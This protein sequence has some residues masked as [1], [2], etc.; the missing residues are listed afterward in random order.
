MFHDV[1]HI[2]DKPV[3]ILLRDLKRGA[4]LPCFPNFLVQSFGVFLQF[5]A[6]GVARG[7]RESLNRLGLLRF[8]IGHAAAY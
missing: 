3:D 8:K 4:H 6:H 7:V 2:L 5:P 1:F